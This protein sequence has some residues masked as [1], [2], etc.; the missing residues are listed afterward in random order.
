M[1]FHKVI[2]ATKTP[3]KKVA[4]LTISALLVSC[5]GG[6]DGH[7]GPSY[8]NQFS[9]ASRT[10]PAAY[11]SAKAINYS[12]YRTTLGPAQNEIPSDDQIKQDLTLLSNAGFTLIR[13]FDSDTAHANI[14]R[15]A[16]SNFPNLKFQ[17]GVFL[18]GIS[19]ANGPNCYNPDNDNHVSWGV[20]LANTYS[21][22]VSVSVG[23]ETSNF[24]NGNSFNPM[25]VNCLAGYITTVKKNVSQPVTTDDVADFYAGAKIANG[26]DPTSIL[27][28]IDFASIHIYP[29]QP[30]S[31]GWGYNALTT[32][33][34]GFMSGAVGYVQTMYNLVSAYLTNSSHGSM[35][36]VIGETGWKNRV[37]NSTVT[38]ETCGVSGGGPCANPINQR[39]FFDQLNS[40]TG[41]SAIFWF[42]AFDEAWKTNDDGW[43]LWLANRTPATVTCDS[44]MTT[45]C[46]P[47]TGLVAY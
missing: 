27:A 1:I 39:Y 25:P 15:V 13:I 14:L 28:L 32:S 3:W 36:I 35:P 20:K 24:L 26:E 47:Y 12:P 33:P 2:R 29:T 7:T 10:L 31:T 5:G 38:L 42:E 17:L 22:V 23:N 37:T 46:T 30:G 18:Y 8:T 4:L 45:A 6:G 16:A 40:V 41:P 43:G 11:T 44:L 34:T 19:Q 21:N 9:L